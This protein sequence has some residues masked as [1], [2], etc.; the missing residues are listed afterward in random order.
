M[1]IIFELYFGE[2]IAQYS[3]FCSPHRSYLINIIMELDGLESF[4]YQFYDLE[5][6]K[7]TCG[8]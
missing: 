8:K 4:M 1:R 6:T 5:T 7:S 2:A 3:I